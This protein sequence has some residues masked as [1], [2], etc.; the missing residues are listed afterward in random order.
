MKKPIKTIIE[1][2]YENKPSIHFERVSMRDR[3][4]TRTNTAQ[5][6]NG[7]VRRANELALPVQNVQTCEISIHYHSATSLSCMKIVKACPCRDGGHKTMC[8]KIQALDPKMA[9]SASEPAGS[10]A[11]G[12]GE[13]KTDGG[14][15]ARPQGGQ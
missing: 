8:K 6:E 3:D 1:R 9:G 4:L 11:S 12:A 14:D 15:G 5:E 13:S 10:A 7:A 2:A